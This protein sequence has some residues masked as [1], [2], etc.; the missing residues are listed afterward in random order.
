MWEEG[1]RGCWGCG[2]GPHQGPRPRQ[3]V[4]WDRKE[5]LPTKTTAPSRRQAGVCLHPTCQQSPVVP[6]SPP[7]HT[8]GA[9]LG[10]AQRSTRL[11][12]LGWK[13]HGCPGA[14]RGLSER[15]LKVPELAREGASWTPGWSDPFT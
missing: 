14:E 10:Q 5:Q 7:A 1:L 4:T 2:T 6:P 15:V 11:V 8:S 9:A 3:T 12:G 13:G